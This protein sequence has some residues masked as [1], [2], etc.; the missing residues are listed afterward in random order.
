LAEEEADTDAEEADN[1][2]VFPEESMVSDFFLFI[3]FLF[4]NNADAI[5]KLNRL[6]M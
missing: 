3:F 2:G 4:V 5:Y 6:K 1:T